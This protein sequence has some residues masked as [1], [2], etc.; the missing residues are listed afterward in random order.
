MA[1][2][3]EL[4]RFGMEALADGL[5]V[6]LPDFAFQ[7][8]QLCTTTLPLATDTIVLVVVVVVFQMPLSVSP[9][10]GHGADGVHELTREMLHK[11]ERRTVPE[12][13][14]YGCLGCA[15]GG[16]RAGEAGIYY[17]A[18]AMRELRGPSHECVPSKEARDPQLARRLWDLSMDLT[19]IDPGLP[20]IA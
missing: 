9:S 10:S 12:H 16:D 8:E 6:F 19:G 4:S 20:P 3:Q 15:S 13:A 14:G 7:S 11:A 17:G 5:K 18:K 2:T 1:W